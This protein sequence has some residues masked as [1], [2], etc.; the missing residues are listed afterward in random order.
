MSTG[1]TTYAITFRGEAG[2]TVRAAFPD[3]D[4]STARGVTTLRA[5]L[6]DQASLH[7]VIDRIRAMGLEL[8]SVQAVGDGVG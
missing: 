8:L 1:A 7:G 5:T 4:V 6:P 2:R 3:L